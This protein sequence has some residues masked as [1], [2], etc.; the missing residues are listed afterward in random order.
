MLVRRVVAFVFVV[1][2]ALATTAV[3]AG[4]AGPFDVPATAPNPYAQPQPGRMEWFQDLK[5]GLF[6]HWGIYCAND[7]RPA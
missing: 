3:V 4:E 6:M 5:L 7:E 2:A 1:L